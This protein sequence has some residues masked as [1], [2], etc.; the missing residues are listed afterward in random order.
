[1][2][3]IPLLFLVC[4]SLADDRQISPAQPTEVLTGRRV[5]LVIGNG[6]YAHTGRLA[7]A[8]DDARRV[9]K[10]LQADGFDVTARYDLALR[11]MDKVVLDFQGRLADADVGFF[12]YSG[13]ALQIADHNYLVPV[14]ANLTEARYVSVEA[15]DVMKV[16]QAMD[17]AGSDLNVVVLDAC[18][19]NPWASKWLAGQKG[20]STSQGLAS[21]DA[22]SGFIVAYA[23][24]PGSVAADDGTYA[25]SLEKNLLTPGREIVEVFSYVHEDVKTTSGEGQI[26]WVSLAKGPAR[27][28]PAG[29][30]AG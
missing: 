22:P 26:P 27:F 30:P 2:S 21:M 13:H 25:A 18:R 12:Y 5:A 14:D 29:A 3:L 20:V 15:L 10:A 24:G 11:D 23:T 7:R 17:N 19:N 16:L 1:M 4:Q 8:P 28:Y 9:A 6:D